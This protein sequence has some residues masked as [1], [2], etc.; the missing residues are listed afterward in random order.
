MPWLNANWHLA[1]N[2]ASASRGSRNVTRLGVGGTLLGLLSLNHH[3]GKVDITAIGVL[4][5]IFTRVVSRGI[6]GI[7][8]EGLEGVE[9]HGGTG[10]VGVPLV[11]NRLL[12]FV[13]PKLVIVLSI[14][15]E[16]TNRRAGAERGRGESRGGSNNGEKG[17]DLGV[18][19]GERV[20]SSWR[21]VDEQRNFCIP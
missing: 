9:V 7:S 12:G 13:V 20:V 5:K 10:A 21:Q 16:N 17:K 8:L 3:L 2:L 1:E 18:H 19:H 6:G 14:R 15:L 4:V 11:V